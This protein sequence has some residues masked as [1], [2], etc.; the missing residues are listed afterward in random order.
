LPARLVEI[1]VP[2]ASGEHAATEALD[3]LGRVC[4]EFSGPD[5]LRELCG[6]DSLAAFDRP[7]G[8]LLGP[9]DSECGTA[10]FSTIYLNS[11]IDDAKLSPLAQL[12]TLTEADLDYVQITDHGLRFLESSTRLRRLCLAHTRITDAGVDRLI[13]FRSLKELNIQGTQIS[14]FGFDRL[15]QGLP[16]CKI[17]H[18]PT[19]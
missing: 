15:C 16:D 13:R 9:G 2:S 12:T 7:V 10:V 17:M 4:I 14:T 6:D 3:P 18:E 5:W 8:L 1:C 19:R 11:Q